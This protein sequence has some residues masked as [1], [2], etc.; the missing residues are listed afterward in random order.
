MTSYRF[1]NLYP[2][3]REK[4]LNQTIVPLSPRPVLKEE[5]IHTNESVS[6]PKSTSSGNTLVILLL[7][8]A[9]DMI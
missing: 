9:M 7:L 5:E 6:P 4:P 2:S 1:E 3:S 8:L